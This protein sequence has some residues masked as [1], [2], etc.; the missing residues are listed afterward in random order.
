MV[1]GL[2]CL[3][4]KRMPTSAGWGG[5]GSAP[6]R[7]PPAEV[8]CCC[9]EHRLVVVWGTAAPLVLHRADSCGVCDGFPACGPVLQVGSAP[10]SGKWWQFE[11]YAGPGATKLKVLIR[12]HC[13]FLEWTHLQWGHAAGTAKAIQVKDLCWFSGLFWLWASGE[14]GQVLCD[15]CHCVGSKHSSAPSAR[16]CHSAD[17]WAAAAV[18]SFGFFVFFLTK[19]CRSSST[20]QQHLPLL[21]PLHKW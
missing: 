11:S 7:G 18:S 14:I 21:F 8:G 2:L 1:P 13:I 9:W 17:P 15:L 19:R 3:L 6:S 10:C 16:R 20:A 5:M 4:Q 12:A